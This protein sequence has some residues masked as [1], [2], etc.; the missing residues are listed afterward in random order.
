M[1][2]Y[3]ED[4]PYSTVTAFEIFEIIMRNRRFDIQHIYKISHKFEKR[5]SFLSFVTVWSLRECVAAFSRRIFCVCVFLLSPVCIRR[6]SSATFQVV[7]VVVNIVVIR[8]VICTPPRRILAELSESEGA[9]IRVECVCD[10]TSVC[11]DVVV[12]LLV[13]TAGD[14]LSSEGEREAGG[15]SFRSVTKRRGCIVTS[16]ELVYRVGK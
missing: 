5:L 2:A 13:S 12:S 6:V 4:A 11:E 9:S 15:S 7:S 3:F 1:S 14:R 10:G 16:R 8:I